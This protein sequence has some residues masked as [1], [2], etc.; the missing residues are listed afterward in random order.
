MTEWLVKHQG[1]SRYGEPALPGPEYRWVA[2]EDAPAPWECGHT[3]LLLSWTIRDVESVRCLECDAWSSW[4]LQDKYRVN[5]R[6]SFDGMA[7][8]MAEDV[9]FHA[10]KR[11][12]RDGIA[13]RLHRPE[14]GDGR[15]R[16]G[17]RRA[18][19]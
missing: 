7:A 13:F 15:V 6:L 10:H 1:N 3:S 16:N 9:A 12:P 19:A 14:V 5:T 17:R 2:R 11:E 18:A 4:A 8:A